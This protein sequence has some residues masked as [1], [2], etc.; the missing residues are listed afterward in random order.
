MQHHGRTEIQRR[1]GDLDGF[2]NVDG[3]VFGRL[4]CLS[5]GEA[6]LPANQSSGPARRGEKTGFAKGSIA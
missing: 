3:T 1:Q 4:I 6:R 5:A 2:V